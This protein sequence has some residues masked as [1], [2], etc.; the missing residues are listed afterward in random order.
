MG[1]DHQEGLDV[2]ERIT[3]KLNLKRNRMGYG[4]D[5]SGSG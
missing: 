4:Q 1:R 3:L 2:D 5:S